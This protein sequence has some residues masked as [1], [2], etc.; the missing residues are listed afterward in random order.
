MDERAT[1]ILLAAV[2]LIQLILLAAQVPDRKLGG[3]TLL[4]GSGLRAA[5][6]ALDAI[7]GSGDLLSAIALAIRDRQGLRRENRQLRRE[8]GLLRHETA[9]Q[10][11]LEDEVRRL[12]RALEYDPPSERSVGVA[13]I[14]F[15][16]H[17]SW[18]RTLIIRSVEEALVD[19]APVTTHQGLVGRIIETD[20][21]H[22]R[23]QLITDRSSSVGAMLERTR[24]QGIARG[25]TE[26]SL[27]LDYVPNRTDV[28]LGDRVVTAGNDGIYPRGLNIGTVTAIERGPESFY[29][30]EL[31]PAVDL[32]SL[33][34][35]FVLA[36]LRPPELEV[37]EA[38]AT[39]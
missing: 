28:Q 25:A 24:R 35:V 17:H 27:L 36:P 16:D 20:R 26:G 39:R 4:Q 14:V 19:N 9:L 3:A 1:A 33:D 34:E 2:L 21:T 37:P 13:D 6:P 8:V 23:V 18:L 11:E 5:R 31:V 7:K 12:R 22:A 32:G 15:I 29:R 30:I 38:D 10:R